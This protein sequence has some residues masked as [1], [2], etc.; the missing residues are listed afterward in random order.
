MAGNRQQTAF[1]YKRDVKSVRCGQ[2]KPF[3][4]AAQ[5]CEADRQSDN[6]TAESAA[7]LGSVRD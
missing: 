5:V 7:I 3:T 6:P 4:D 2:G 1:Y